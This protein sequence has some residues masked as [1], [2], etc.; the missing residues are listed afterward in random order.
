MRYFSLFHRHTH[1]LKERRLL[2]LAAAETP[3]ES[4][5]GVGRP[6]LPD[7]IK[8]MRDELAA[9]M[10]GTDSAG[11][12]CEEL[13]NCLVDDGKL[14]TEDL[15]KLG[16]AIV[17]KFSGE[18]SEEMRGR[19]QE[20]IPQTE[21]EMLELLVHK[22][23]VL[24]FPTYLKISQ[25]GVRNAGIEGDPFVQD[26][27]NNPKPPKGCLR[28]SRFVNKVKYWISRKSET[29][30][31][32]LDG[33]PMGGEEYR[34]YNRE[35]TRASVASMSDESG[36]GVSGDHG[37]LYA[38]RVL[39]MNDM[40]GRGLDPNYIAN[41]RTRGRMGIDDHY[42]SQQDYNVE[43]HLLGKRDKI[44]SR[45]YG[46]TYLDVTEAGIER[47]I[48]RD[49]ARYVMYGD[50]DSTPM[51]SG[52]GR[53]GYD[54]SRD[55]PYVLGDNAEYSAGTK[56]YMEAMGDQYL[57]SVKIAHER[58]A[59]I[60]RDTLLHA[61]D[62][63]T[64]NPLYKTEDPYDLQGKSNQLLARRMS[65]A[66]SKEKYKE[67]A[68]LLSQFDQ[69]NRSIA[70]RQYFAPTISPDAEPA[71]APY[72]ALHLVNRNGTRFG[73]N[74]TVMIRDEIDGS[75]IAFNPMKLDYGLLLDDS[76]WLKDRGIVLSIQRQQEPAF[77]A[78]VR[79]PV[80]DLKIFAKN[81]GSSFY[82][83]DNMSNVWHLDG[84]A[85][86]SVPQTPLVRDTTSSDSSTRGKLPFDRT[87]RSASDGYASPSASDIIPHSSIERS[88]STR[89]PIVDP[90][91]P[92]I[93]ETA[94]I[95]SKSLQELADEITNKA[96]EGFLYSVATSD[97]YSDGEPY[98]RIS[99][100]RRGDLT[101]VVRIHILD[102]VVQVLDL[103]NMFKSEKDASYDRDADAD[104]T[105]PDQIAQHILK[106]C[107][108]VKPVDE[109]PTKP[110]DAIPAEYDLF[111][112]RPKVEEPAK[113]KDES[114]VTPEAEAK[115]KLESRQKLAEAISN[116]VSGALFQCDAPTPSVVFNNTIDINV[117]RK[118][119]NELV[120]MVDVRDT[121]VR[122]LDASNLLSDPLITYNRDETAD[123]KIAIDAALFIYDKYVEKEP[124]APK[125]SEEI[126]S[127]RGLVAEITKLGK[128][129]FEFGTVLE[130][131][132]VLIGEYSIIPVFLAGGDK[133]AEIAITPTNV[134]ITNIKDEFDVQEFS[135][136]PDEV[137]PQTVVDFLVDKYAK[138][139]E[140][141]TEKEAP[142]EEKVTVPEAS[143]ASASLKKFAQEIQNLKQD[144]FTYEGEETVIPEDGREASL[145]INVIPKGD[146]KR[147]AHI[148]IQKSTVE[149][150]NDV[151]WSDPSLT[152]DRIS[153][154]QSDAQKILAFLIDTFA[155]EAK[156]PAE[157]AVIAPKPEET[158]A[159]PAD[160][161]PEK[162]A[163]EPV[164][165]EVIDTLAPLRKLAEDIATQLPAGFSYREVKVNPSFDGDPND[166]SGYL[167]VP[168][169]R[170]S[171]NAFVAQLIVKKDVVSVLNELDELH[172]K[173]TL[174]RK[175]VSDAAIPGEVAH[176][177]VDT[178]TKRAEKAEVK[179]TDTAE[180]AKTDKP[181][182]TEVLTKM[183][184]LADSIVIL[185]TDKFN[186]GLVDEKIDALLGDSLSVSV[187]NKKDGNQ[188]A[189]IYLSKERVEIYDSAVLFPE[190]K[191]FERGT[192][193]E[194]LSNEISKYLV[195]TF[196]KAPEGSEAEKPEV[197]T[198][199]IEGTPAGE[200]KPAAETVPV[201]PQEPSTEEKNEEKSTIVEDKTEEVPLDEKPMEDLDSVLLQS[202]KMQVDVA[203]Q[204]SVEY[205]NASE[206]SELMERV[207]A[208]DALRENLQEINRMLKADATRDAMQ[209]F[210]TEEVITQI[211]TAPFIFERDKL[212]FREKTFED[213]R[214]TKEQ[215]APKTEEAVDS[216]A[217]K[218]SEIM[219]KQ[220][221]RFGTS[222]KIADVDTPVVRTHLEHLAKVPDGI[223]RQ[224][225]LRGV[226]VQISNRDV[227][228]ISN[229]PKWLNAPRGWDRKN[230]KGIPGAYDSVNS[231][232]YAGGGIPTACESLILHE[233]GHAIGEYLL[234][235]SAQ[236][237]IEA[238][239][240]LYNRL[241]EY[242][243]QGGRGGLAGRQEFFA[244]S[245]SDYLMF[246]KEAFVKEYDEEWYN[247]MATF[248]QRNS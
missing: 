87:K 99:V 85:T 51:R 222:L 11:E 95:N 7:D 105:I 23:E 106:T 127:Q 43:M 240:R 238:H 10:Q 34:Q 189:I 27:G 177:L 21:E 218:A 244:E 119:D 1:S 215:D 53:R 2:A 38:M 57:N 124:E 204:L 144:A 4:G 72:V 247:Y 76:Q 9:I 25:E 186:Y 111:A 58:G 234:Q 196:P 100:S 45:D 42:L 140:K 19:L 67:Y 228:G 148:I 235:D 6:D 56:G 233:Y 200:E 52:R 54:I 216:L 32:V 41:K 175:E 171:D 139:P 180:G 143:E 62:Q 160:E 199:S 168:I 147:V 193:D 230:W 224:L 150:L 134:K 220:K 217:K 125:V 129:K 172:G 75:S 107:K 108:E 183:H 182:D 35:V 28:R 74:Y 96:P 70:M 122:I 142:A 12:I 128:E 117:R 39:K 123:K 219:A 239:N 223:V 3:D 211:E 92:T 103:T 33:P 26:L 65:E 246:P 198:P 179:P 36:D 91:V 40:Q 197:A 30:P 68:H 242:Y 208:F 166:A 69:V 192:D 126:L 20:V 155:P 66:L 118:S 130:T 14:L 71:D 131:P 31:W 94:E 88:G 133:V 162:P 229:N 214:I 8:R 245:F 137:N 116:T 98:L 185:A 132:D 153:D 90:R 248:I 93:P 78:T 190:P 207:N 191:I 170:E 17:M 206:R 13:Q 120:A 22:A 151:E 188:V 221:E 227:P 203:V 113:T 77:N 141:P 161:S 241:Y 59:S 169:I 49:T 154:D 145:S 181:K 243:K 83:E 226:T 205:Q 156:M 110:A 50:D 97:P 138:E 157:E 165:P 18:I 209:S 176:F 29:D 86:G 102:K 79:H 46:S 47:G 44:I 114:S 73:M 187:M 164:K 115:E 16:Y 194:S 101:E 184:A 112:E 55:H 173:Y 158:D 24:T 37:K 109:T 60:D 212:K 236:S 136:R 231:I 210:L 64:T 163:E 89:D 63:L 202:L 213:Y 15:E 225:A 167:F 81:A 146:S 104:K 174:D 195:A 121:I 149:V 80:R 135:R 48:A 237:V 5:S 232:V 152:F 178:L 61:Y 82:I 159:K 201:K 84:A